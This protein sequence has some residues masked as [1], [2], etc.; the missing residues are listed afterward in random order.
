M[1]EWGSRHSPLLV[2]LHGWGD[3]GVSFQF[4]VDALA[5]DWFVIAPDW[6]GFGLSRSRCHSYWFPDY[7][8]DLDALLAIYQADAPVNLVGHSMGANVAGLYA[9]TFPE[10]VSAFVN[11]EGF[12]LADSDPSEAPRTYRRWI[13]QGRQMPAFKTYASFGELAGRIRKRSPHMSP[14]RALFVA[15]HW[16][17]QDPGG[18]VR[19]RADPAHRLPNAVQYRRAEATACW[20]RVTAAVLLLVGEETDFKGDLKP[21]L[22]PDES[23]HPFR[24]APSVIIPEAGHMVHFES[25]AELA[26][27]VEAFV[28]PGERDR[29]TR[30]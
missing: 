30:P 18:T 19:L 17:V 27:A 11:V 3:C 24:G 23:R 1:Y 28:R 21:W 8:A 20:D 25:P 22:D 2:L 12:G 4:M 29:E 5:G 10:R 26:A 9:G 13:E 14:D 15:R 6:R 16:A 7:I